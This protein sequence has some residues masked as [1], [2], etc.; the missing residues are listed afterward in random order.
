MNVAAQVASVVGCAGLVALYLAPSR[1]ARLAG[2]VVWAAGL[3][4]LG[5]TLLPDLSWTK[6][7]AAAVGGVV[8]AI[9]VA[10]I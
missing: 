6:L 2:L 3:G 1:T 8:A 4:V 10:L 5:Y 7:A 9:V